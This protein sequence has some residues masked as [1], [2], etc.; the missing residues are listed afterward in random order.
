M[1]IMSSDKK[2]KFS[3][4]NIL[5]KVKDNDRYI[6]INDK[7]REDLQK[8]LLS[9]Y[10]DIKYVCEKYGL[11]LFLCGGSALGAVR[12]K[13]FIPWD[14]DLDMSMTRD[15]YNRFQDIF[16]KELSD[17]YL[18][19]APGYKEGSRARFP[20]IMKKGTIF[21]EMGN[22]SPEEECGVFLDIFILDRV[23]DNAFCMK[24]KGVYCNILEFISGQVLWHEEKAE[25][26]YKELE[27]SSKL[28]LFI[29]RSIGM[30]FSF[31][32][33]CAWN[34]TLDRA[35]QY[36][37]DSRCYGLLTG[38]KHYFG[39]ILPKEAFLPGSHG[40]FEGHEVLLF[41]DTDA[42]LTNLYGEYMKIPDE[43]DRET[44]VVEE[45]RF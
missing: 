42:Y 3:A 2:G 40:I 6:E 25:A 15:D 41:S 21:R 43:S 14:D 7:L 22:A 36:K 23:P 26:V 11:S 1:I 16:E 28:Q 24:I 8:L 39:E 37:K 9:M 33:V 20:K 44:H 13:G 34:R 38:R 18:L 30:L 19:K 45:I 4:K 12:H 10:L 17:K 29:R 35:I 32:S 31:R 27:K 5:S